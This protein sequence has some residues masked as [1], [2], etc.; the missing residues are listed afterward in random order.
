MTWLPLISSPKQ[1][2]WL[3]DHVN[4]SNARGDLP[5]SFVVTDIQPAP[6][7]FA[8]ATVTAHGNGFMALIR[9]CRLCWSTNRGVG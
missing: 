7:N 5:Y 9:L 1:A 8:G 6:N 3:D 2:G 4:Q